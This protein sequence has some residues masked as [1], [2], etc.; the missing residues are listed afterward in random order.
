M[1]S[2]SVGESLKEYDI[3]GYPVKF[4]P[5]SRGFIK[6][7]LAML[8]N[9]SERYDVEEK[10]GLPE[11]TAELFELLDAR[12]EFVRSEIDK[13]FGAGA[14]AGIFPGDPLAKSGGLPLWLN[15]WLDI[16]DELDNEVCNMESAGNEKLKLYMN[17][18]K[19][20]RRK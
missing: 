19:K 12:E 11:N 16:L 20:Y 5:T 3:N 4:D 15:L 1:S 9:I 2:I 18:Y 6:R 7:F 13:V 10:A 17:K 14:S 8:E